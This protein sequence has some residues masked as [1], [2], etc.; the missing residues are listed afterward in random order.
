MSNTFIIVTWNNE[1]EICDLVNS[2]VR[3]ESRSKIIVADNASTD[4]TVSLLRAMK[5]AELTIITLTKNVGFAA[6]NNIAFKRVTTPYVTFI[7]PDTKL[8]EPV[9]NHLEHELDGQIGLIGLRLENRDHSLQPSIFKFQRPSEI[10]IEQFALGRIMP[11]MLRRKYS[12]ENSRHDQKM[13]VDWVIGAFMFTKA[14]YYKAVNGFSE[15]YFLYSED[16]DLCYKYHQKG[17]AVLFDPS[18]TILH[19]GGSSE[20]QTSTEKNIKLLRSFCIFAQKF[21][22][23]S[24]IKALY[25]SYLIKWKIF[26]AI[27]PQRAK[28]YQNNV[29]FLKERLK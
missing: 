28:K 6:A 9:I 2:I 13:L 17:L 27:D 12:P 29:E 22:L 23:S 18:K 19:V 3:Y 11:E 16:M 25:Y 7:N 21:G 15:D 4:K 14:S 24:N 5:L 20:E 8:Q 26:R 10:I 1:K